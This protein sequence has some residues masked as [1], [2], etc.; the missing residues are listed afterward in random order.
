MSVARGFGLNG[1]S[2]YTNVCKPC[3]VNLNFI[4]DSTNG[5]G[6]GIRSPKSNGYVESVFMHTTQTPGIVNGVTNPNPVAGYAVIT[7]KNNFNYYLGGFSGQIT[8]LTSTSTTS[9]TTG[10]VYVITV[11]GTT[12]VAQ[13]QTAGLPQGITPAVGVAF[14]AIATAS[15][16]GTGTVGLPSSPIADAVSVVGDPNTSLN[17][18]NIAKNAGAKILIQFNGYTFTAGAYTP[19]GTNS[20][21][22]FTGSALG[23]HTHD[24]T[25]IGGQAGSTTNNIANYAGPLIGKQEATNATYIGANSATNGGVVAGSAG[26]PAGT[27]SAPTFTGTPSSLTGTVTRTVLSPADGTVVGMTFKFDGSS[28]TI[29]GI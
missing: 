10:H 3:D 20:V 18:S 2:F 1:K 6:L 14:V 21:P 8:P 29:D 7:F 19:A 25:V 5:N 24:F 16:S 27:V 22:T 9:L 26:T 23:T 28:V 11:V 17:N 13:W 12:T 15:L 4:V